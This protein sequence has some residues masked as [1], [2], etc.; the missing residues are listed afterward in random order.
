MTRPSRL[1]FEF[2]PPH[3]IEATLRLWRSVE[4]LAPLAPDFVSVT[5]GAG[6]ATRDRTL[7][8]I[9]VIHERARLDVAGHLTCVGASKSETLSIARGYLARGASRIVALRGDPPAGDTEFRAHEDGFRSGLELVEGLA[10]A[11]FKDIIVAAYPEIHPQAVSGSADLDTLKAK[12]DAGATMAITQFCF[13]PATFLDFRERAMAHG[14]TIPIVPGVLPVEDFART[15]RFSAK[16]GAGIP[17]WMETA[18]G[19]AQTQEEADL[20]A[21]AIATDFCD[22]LLDEG[23]E[24][25]HF[26][27]LNNPDLVYNIVNTLGFASSDH[28]SLEGTGAA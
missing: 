6:G 3:S 22:T 7:D 14:I 15:R 23:V 26:Y 11:G 27:T 28:L 21:I 20:L 19:N 4:R 17:G 10:E 2:F 13:D 12:Q 24:Q 25:L 8:A 1:S 18:F 16:C 9:K 5:Y